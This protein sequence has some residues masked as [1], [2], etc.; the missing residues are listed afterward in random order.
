MRTLDWLRQKSVLKYQVPYLRNSTV[1]NDWLILCLPFCHRNTDRL[2]QLAE[3]LL[4][5][6][7]PAA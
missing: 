4:A 2:L 1:E 7:F 3:N 6:S 5:I